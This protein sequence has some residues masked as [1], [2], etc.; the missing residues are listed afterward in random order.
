MQQGLLV[1]SS[2]VTLQGSL[3][4]KDWRASVLARLC[5]ACRA[6]GRGRRCGGRGHGGRGRR[7]D[8]GCSRPVGGPAG[9]AFTHGLAAHPAD[10]RAAQ[11]VP[12]TPRPLLALCPSQPFGC[13]GAL[14]EA[15]SEVP[16]AA[17]PAPAR[18]AA[19]CAHCGVNGWAPSQD[20][21]RQGCQST[22]TMASLIHLVLSCSPGGCQRPCAKSGRVC[23]QLFA[24]NR[25]LHCRSLQLDHFFADTR[26][27]MG[28]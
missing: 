11:R 12:G 3:Y 23:A 10:L 7:G 24:R 26:A 2:D 22:A 28:R 25:L 21:C 8:A 1:E 15:R 19:H 6:G 5:A 9:G 13:G 17:A 18:Q 20:A 14:V 16:R 4:S 27:V